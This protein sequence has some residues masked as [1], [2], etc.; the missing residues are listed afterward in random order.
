MLL[1]I[2]G[3]AHERRYVRICALLDSEATLKENAED[4]HTQG[5]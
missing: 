4:L 3:A 5:F 1:Q 2:N